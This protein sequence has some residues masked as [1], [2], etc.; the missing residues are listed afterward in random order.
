MIRDGINVRIVITDRPQKFFKAFTY[1]WRG[2]V[3]FFLNDRNGRIHLGA[4]L[5][6]VLAG[7]T[8]RISNI[9]WIIILL[10]IGLVIAFEMINASIEKLCD[11][12]H[13]DFHPTIKIIKDVSAA[14]VL[15]VSVVS[16]LVATIIFF[17][18]IITL[19]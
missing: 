4:A 1:A 19:L 15:W 3:H 8:L 13:K 9:E 17:P 7:F 12:V 6:A 18:K 16:F 11:V 10:C 2:I 5:A 14:G